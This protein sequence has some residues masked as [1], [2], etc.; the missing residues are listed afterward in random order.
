MSDSSN[1]DVEV[2]EAAMRLPVEARPAYLDQACAGDGELRRQV[3]SLLK[4][5]DRVGDFLEK[6][7]LDGVIRGAQIGEKPGSFIGRYKLLAQ[8]GEGGCGVVYLAEQKEPVRRRVALKIIKP[9][10]DTKSVIAR[11]E[12]ERQTLALM[13]HP[14]IAK[15]FDAGATDSGR[16]FFVMELVQGVKITEYCDENALTTEERLQLFVQVCHAVQHAH[17]KGIIH[18]DIKPSNILVTKTLEGVALPV[19]IDFGIAK[20]TTNQPLTDKTVFT[21]FE[22][23][24]GTPAYMSPE[25][26]AL[27]KID[28][29][30][31]TDIYSLGVL[32]YELL[33]GKTPFDAGDL[34]KVGLDEV[35]RVIREQEPSRPSTR[36]SKMT[37]A[38]LTSVAERRKS[39]APKLIRVVCGDLDWI[40]MKA[41]EKDPTRRYE[42]ANGL[43]LDVQRYLANDVISARPP[44]RLYRFRKLVSRNKLLFS[45]IGAISILL[46]TSLVLVTASLRQ[47]RTEAAKS[48][49]TTQFLEDMLREVGPSVAPG[50]NTEMLKGILDKAAERAGTELSNQPAVEAELR[51][52]M[53]GAYQD[54]GEYDEAEKMHRAALALDRKLFGPESQQ[55]AASLNGLGDALSSKGQWVEAE[56]AFQQALRIRR[57]VFG[58]VNPNVAESL[59]SLADM[60][61]NQGNVPEAV[62]LAQQA[63][64]I[65][66]QYYGNDSLEVADTLRDLAILLGDQDKREECEALMRQVLAI[67]RKKLPADHPQVA[68]ALADVAWAAGFRDKLEEAESLER[69]ALAMRQR[70]LDPGHPDIATSLYTVGSRLLQRKKLGEA[71][72]FLTNALSMQRKVFGNTHPTTLN[73]F[74]TVAMVLEAQGNLPEAEAMHREI[75]GSWR[76]NG[77]IQTPVAEI[78][79]EN[80]IHLLMIEKKFG[81]AEQIADEMLTPEFKKNPISGTLLTLRRDLKARTCQ[82]K[83]A[84]ADAVLASD[85]Q[86]L[87]SDRYA[88]LAALLIQTG[89]LPA[90]ESLRKKLLGMY[91]NTTDFYSADQVAKACLFLPP[92][93]ADLPVLARLA[94]MPVTLGAADSG[95][96]PYFQVCKALSEYRQG[97]FTQA[98]DWAQRTVKTTAIY[99]QGQAYAVLAMADW[100]LGQKDQ[101]R[102]MLGLGNTVAARIYPVRY[103]EDPLNTWAAWLFGRISL[104]EASALI[105]TDP[106]A[107][108]KAI[109][110]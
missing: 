22:M 6:T 107:N 88:K 81:D 83:E 18:R 92:A 82:W 87:R 59:N 73:T 32:L 28:V 16:P 57:K 35:R 85:L 55:S 89:N 103:E 11:F 69:E 17:Q 96:M 8:I 58:N 34:L 61:R 42:T 30:T 106:T 71:Y 40:A 36:L 91:A 63:L 110:P 10:M 48:Q 100:R 84:E 29:D 3:E 97:H 2:F 74:R 52:I 15:V 76:A 45:A 104:D 99:A 60:Y 21:A 38:D 13:D 41:L 108:V 80:L 65:R 66:Q 67:R 98:A 24:I 37:Q 54:L 25:Q 20:A 51:G 79:L 4:V 62:A 77:K 31:R 14:N 26:A 109:K 27:S 5:H 49:Q 12:A 23:L 70:V 1:R 86:P 101:A 75:L 68:S 44:S 43:A 94:D 95:A 53:G 50:K 105:H 64:E 93:E 47:A 39:E 72:S 56:S 9:G 7:P 46:V 102:L 90:Y 78:E 33:T 19:V